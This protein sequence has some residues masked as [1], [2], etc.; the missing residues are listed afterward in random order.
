MAQIQ[1][2]RLGSVQ[3]DK[4]LIGTDVVFEKAPTDTTPPITSIRPYDA[5]NNPTNT[6]TTA[7]TV[8]LDTN[9]MADTY[10]TLDGGTPTTASAHYQGDGILIDATKTIKYFSIDQSGNAETVKSLTYT[11]TGE[12]PASEVPAFPRY[13]RYI[14]YGDNLS[15]GT[16]RLVEFQV[17]RAGTNLLLNK[18]PISGEPVSTGGTIDKVTDG[19]TTMSGYP[20][21]W[22]GEGIPTL[23]YDLGD[24]LDITGINVWM[25]STVNDPRITKFKVQVSTDN[26]TYVDVIDYQFNNTV[27]QPAGGWIFTGM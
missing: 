16:T 3:V 24:W 4:I 15:G 14:G 20:I 26:V 19:L 13:I 27:V 6:Y 21:W 18:L 10:Y 25:Y 11:I 22:S 23:T 17:I 9:E 5:T 7:Q 8:Y 1:D 2:V 12:P